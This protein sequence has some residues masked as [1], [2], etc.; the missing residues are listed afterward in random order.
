[1]VVWLNSGVFAPG[2]KDPTPAAALT[3]S[4]YA[5]ASIEYRTGSEAPFPAQLHDAKAAIRWLRA[6]AEQYNL[7]ASNIGVWGFGG[8]GNLAAL[9]GTT[10]DMAELEGD[11]GNP[12][13]SSSVQ[14]VV[15]FS[16]PVDLLRMDAAG[17]NPRSTAADAPEAVWIGGPL[18]DNQEKVR[19]V[20]P[21]TYI[22][23]DDPPFLL[24]HGTADAEVPTSQSQIL[25]SALK[26]AGLNA[27]LDLQVGVPHDVGSLLTQPVLE[28]VAGFLDQQLRGVR[29][30]A[31]LS[32]YLSTPSDTMV[33]PIALD[34]GGTLYKT[35]ATPSR[36]PGTIASY[37]VYLPP[38]YE[39]N[40]ARGYPVI[41]FLHGMRVDSKR[42][43][44]AGYVA[45]IDADIR[46]GIIPPVIVVLAQGLNYGWWVDSKDGKN[47]TETVITKDLISHVDA[48]YR[49]IATREARAIE[50]HSMG[51]YG[52]LHIGFNHPELFAAVTGNSAAL[53]EMS[54]VTGTGGSS[55][56]AFEV[57]FG[58]DEEYFEACTPRA[59]AQNNP[60]GLRTQ[61]IRLIVGDQ[62]G[63][64]RGNEALSE[65]LTGLNIPHVFTPVPG[66]PHNHDQLLAYMDFDP[67]A[68]YGD[69]FAG[70]TE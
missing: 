25:V 22:S 30:E 67:M 50:G 16:G 37:R 58:S 51:G 19:A 12:D 2:A 42:P 52:A 68:F 14:A 46:A 49:T 27:T 1:V 57:T 54:G 56:S 21:V 59:I 6:N 60:D 53:V 28:T 41:Y 40:A 66:S 26:V 47:P 18:L 20:N 11:L 8:G 5:I 61:K 69:V 31:G 34:L 43:L 63:L 36:G 3:N 23:E 62:D 9:L 13:Q 4:G 38:D 24:V 64:I 70:V 33:D 48:T 10:G 17:E 65:V 45:R 35:Y 15:D 39:A 44:T 7:D 29:R 32:S 55:G